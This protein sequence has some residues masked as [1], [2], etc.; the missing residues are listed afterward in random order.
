MVRNYQPQD[1]QALATIFKNAILALDNSIYSPRQKQ[2]WLG[3][4]SD[5]FWQSR[6]EQTKPLVAVLNDVV[7]GFIEFGF[8][9]GFGEIGCFYVEPSCQNQ[10]VGQALFGKVLNVAKD[11][12][13]RQ[14][15]VYASHIAKVFFEKQGFRVIQKNSVERERVMLDNWL[16]SCAC[17]VLLN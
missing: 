2:A 5:E 13:V 14:I 4:H 8:E 17:K 10:G 15:Q 16:M 11:N 9:N 6:F 3:N 12:H 1:S 7:V